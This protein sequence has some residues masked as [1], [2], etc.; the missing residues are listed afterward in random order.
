MHTRCKHGDLA[1]ITKDEPGLGANLGRAVRV[2][3][4]KHDHPELGTVWEITPVSALPMGYLAAPGTVSYDRQGVCVIHP[5][6]WMVPVR[7]Q[8]R[9]HRG[10]KFE[11]RVQSLPFT[12]ENIL[13]ILGRKE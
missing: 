7:R 12:R 3:G 9:R 6:T 2:H 13:A 11:P 5:D 10:R 4:P 1:I 8:R